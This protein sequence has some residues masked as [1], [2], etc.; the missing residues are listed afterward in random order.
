MR[1]NLRVAHY[2]LRFIPLA[3]TVWSVSVGV[4]AVLVTTGAV[5]DVILNLAPTGAEVVII[6]MFPVGQN[7]IINTF[8]LVTLIN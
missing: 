3:R 7:P 4:V 1:F 6:F 5:V 2:N 8:S